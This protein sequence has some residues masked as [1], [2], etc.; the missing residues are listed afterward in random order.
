MKTILMAIVGFGLLWLA[1]VAE[2]AAGECI[3]SIPAWGGIEGTGPPTN[4]GPVC[5]LATAAPVPLSD[6]RTTLAEAKALALQ[7]LPE[8]ADYP[9][10]CYEY[11]S[12]YRCSKHGLDKRSP[13]ARMPSWARWLSLAEGAASIAVGTRAPVGSNPTLASNGSLAQIGRRVGFKSRMFPV[14]V[15]GGPSSIAGSLGG[16]QGSYP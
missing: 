12:G 4:P 8:L 14:R 13:P 9:L 2:L 3:E 7:G 16:R 11:A 10:R 6:G 15:R 5:P 1:M